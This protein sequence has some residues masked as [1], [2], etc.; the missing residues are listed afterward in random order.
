MGETAGE[1]L[2]SGLG[3]RRIRLRPGR[4]K[5]ALDE[6][7]LDLGEMLEHVAFLVAMTAVDRDTAAEEGADGRTDGGPAIDHEEDALADVETAIA[8]IGQE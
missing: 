5:T 4:P 8:Q 3:H 1:G 6:W 2:Q 7:P